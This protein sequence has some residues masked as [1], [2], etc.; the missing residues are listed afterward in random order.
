MSKNLADTYVNPLLGPEIRK[1]VHSLARRRYPELFAPN[2]IGGG[3][4]VRAR[5]TRSIRKLMAVQ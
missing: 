4:S 3:F 1:A 5:A 2:C